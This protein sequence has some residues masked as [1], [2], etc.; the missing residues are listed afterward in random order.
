MKKWLA[1]LILGLCMSCSG[2]AW[3]QPQIPSKPTTSI[4]VQDY[5]GVLN[6]DTKNRI[7]NIST[8]LQAKTK[9]QIVV[10]TLPSLEETPPADYALELLRQWGVGDKTLNNGVVLLVSVNDHRSRI[11]VGYGLE[12]ALPDAKTGTIQDEYMLPYFQKEDYDKGILNG[13]MAIAGEVAKEYKLEL[14]TGAK[15]APHPRATNSGS[16]WNNAPWWVHLLIVAGL[17]LLFGADW[18]FFGGTI[19]YL[20]LSL[21]FRGGRGGGSGG[22]GNDGFGGGSGGGGGSDR[23]W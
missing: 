17:L 8:Q 2:I 9:A 19:T 21:L 10:V 12:G 6:A 3:A 23:N 20:I 7:N 13:Y 14:Q 1:W 15:P 18:I 4:Y 11:E 5:A 22:S 16:W